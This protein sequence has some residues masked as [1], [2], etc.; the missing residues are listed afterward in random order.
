MDRGTF[1][2][3]YEGTYLA[4]GGAFLVQRT[5]VCLLLS[6]QRSLHKMSFQLMPRVLSTF[7]LYSPT[8]RVWWVNP[9]VGTFVARIVAFHVCSYRHMQGARPKSN[10]R[11]RP[12]SNLRSRPKSNLRSRPKSDL[13]SRPK[14]NLRSRPKSNLRSRATLNPSP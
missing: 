9:N 3:W 10:L 5:E 4:I 12:K 13:R 2:Y 7:V 11:S 6:V 8:K 14:S 1:W